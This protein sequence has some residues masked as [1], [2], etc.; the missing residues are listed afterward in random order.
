MTSLPRTALLLAFLCLAWAE[1]TSPGLV[2]RI[3]GKGLDYGRCPIPL[4]HLASTQGL[5]FPV[6]LVVARQEGVAVLLQRLTQLSLPEFSGSFKVN[7][8]GH[9]DY[10]FDRLSIHRF[11]L[12]SSAVAPLPGVGLSLSMDQAFAELT[13]QWRVKKRRWFRDHGSFD[14]RV[15]G[16]SISLDLRLGSDAAGKPTAST[17][18]CSAHISEVHVHISSRLG[19]LYNLFHNSIEAALRRSME[20]KI[21]EEVTGS[22][23]SKLQPFLQ[24]MP[25]TAAIDRVAGID[26]AL[27]GPPKATPHALDLDLKGEWFSLDHR[28]ASPSPPPALDFSVGHDRMLYAGISSFF[29]N[30]AGN[31]YF[32]AGAL[33]FQVTD[34]MVPKEF[35]IRLNTSSFGVFAPQVQKSYPNMPMKL[36]VSPSSAPSLTITPGGLTLTPEVDV[37]AFAILPNSTLAPLFVLAAKTTIVAHVSVSSTKISGALKLGRGGSGVLEGSLAPFQERSD[38]V[39]FLFLLH[40]QLQ[41]IQALMNYCTASILVPQMNARLAEGFPL[42]LPEHLQLSNTVLQLHQDFVLV[43][44]DVRWAQ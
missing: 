11:Q 37:Q 6:S 30:T 39:P 24:T 10:D 17:S 29:F 33:S 5:A 9:V 25:V 22:V 42:P 27:A 13:G 26:Y 12:P 15:E 7:L 2:G 14:L 31:V 18:A 3:T 44:A 16:I 23:G 34:D 40:T 4:H 20:D 28:S 21:C 38:H 43:G 19:W 32:K 41:L 36:Q 8:L 35:Q 1:G